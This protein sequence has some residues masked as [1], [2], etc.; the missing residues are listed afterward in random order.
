MDHH[1]G[2][3]AGFDDLVEITD[4]AAAHRARQGPIDPGGFTPLDEKAAD[5]VRCGEIVVAGNG[6]EGPLQAPGHVFH[7][8]G[9]AAAGGA[10]EENGQAVAVGGLENGDLV[11]RGLVI[12]LTFNIVGFRIQDACVHA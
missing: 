12:R 3:L 8:T 1:H 5:Q 10:L 6:D 2:I 7:E 11:P 4:R 9:F